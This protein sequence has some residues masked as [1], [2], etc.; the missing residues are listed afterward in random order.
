[1]YSLEKENGKNGRK[2][3]DGGFSRENEN[4]SR[5][6]MRLARLASSSK[7]GA[8]SVYRKPGPAFDDN[9]R[10]RH[11]NLGIFVLRDDVAGHCDQR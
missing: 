8:D 4:I 3:V 7:I 1:M 5:L 11:G 6:L 2:I 9:K 10:V